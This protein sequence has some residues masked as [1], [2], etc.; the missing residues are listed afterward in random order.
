MG[1]SVKNYIEITGKKHFYLQKS[2]L[3]KFPLN[4]IK[5]LSSLI[6]NRL[7]NAI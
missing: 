6:I 2:S 3:K 1:L 7:Q 5:S 4:I